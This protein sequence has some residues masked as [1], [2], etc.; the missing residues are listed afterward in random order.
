MCLKVKEKN[1][2]AV[3]RGSVGHLQHQVGAHWTDA[4]FVSQT[5][6]NLDIKMSQN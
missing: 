6:E 5:D 1:E 3:T 4:S 2:E